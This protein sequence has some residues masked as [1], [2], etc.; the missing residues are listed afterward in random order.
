MSKHIYYHGAKETRE[1]YDNTNRST[2]AKIFDVITT[3]ITGYFVILFLLLSIIIVTKIVSIVYF[4][5]QI[6]VD[7]MLRWFEF[8]VILGIKVVQ[9][10]LTPLKIIL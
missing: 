6:L 8:W 3:L 10:I 7:M 1:K 5:A 9:L 2:L 4:D